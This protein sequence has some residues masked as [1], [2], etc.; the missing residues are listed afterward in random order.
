MWS[1]YEIYMK[2]DPR[3]GAGTMWER[4]CQFHK[5]GLERAFGVTCKDDRTFLS[6]KNDVKETSVKRHHHLRVWDNTE[7]VTTHEEEK[8]EKD[9]RMETS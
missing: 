2:F 6:N 9:F 4:L 3:G 7:T 8:K 5:I 1:K